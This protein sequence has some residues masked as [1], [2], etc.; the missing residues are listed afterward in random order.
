M[1]KTYTNAHRDSSP[2][3]EAGSSSLCLSA[4]WKSSMTCMGESRHWNNILTSK[5]NS[6]RQHI[7]IRS[8]HNY[9]KGKCKNTWM[10]ARAIRYS[11]TS[12]LLSL[13]IWT[14]SVKILNRS[15]AAG[16]YSFPSSVLFGGCVLSASKILLYHFYRRKQKRG[17]MT[18][19]IIFIYNTAHLGEVTL[20]VACMRS[21]YIFMSG[22]NAPLSEQTWA[23]DSS[24]PRPIRFSWYCTT[25]PVTYSN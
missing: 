9:S 19:I 15:T 4:A 18:I 23:S 21:T 16:V 3:S 7:K 11:M 13:T 20:V 25:Q 14:C 6:R 5:F 1:G 2:T 8:I 10:T 24:T 12:V 22:S 17:Y